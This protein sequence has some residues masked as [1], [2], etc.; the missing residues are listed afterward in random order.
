ML[1]VHKEYFYIDMYECFESQS[2]YETIL[3]WLS[4]YC[5]EF[6]MDVDITFVHVLVQDGYVDSCLTLG[7]FQVFYRQF[8]F[9]SEV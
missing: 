9:S 6:L 2:G 4:S 5:V 1:Y 3:S 8:V 7:G